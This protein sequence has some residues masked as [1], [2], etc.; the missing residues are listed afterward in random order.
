MSGIILRYL[1]GDG[2]YFTIVFFILMLVLA[3]GMITP[4]IVSYNENNWGTELNSKIHNIEITTANF[5]KDKETQLLLTHKK[6][7]QNLLVTLS[8]P[9]TSYRGLIKLVNEEKYN[10]YSVEVLAPNGR[11][12]AWNA[13]IA[14]KEENIFPLTFP[15][16]Q[17]FFHNTE[18]VTYLSVVDTISIE[19]DAFYLVLSFPFEKHYTIQN[20]YFKNTSFIN[21]LSN[22]FYTQFDIGFNS[23]SEKSKDGRKYS[24]DLLN[25]ADKKIGVV[26][27][28]KPS[29][30]S[31]INSISNL[32]DDFQAVLVILACLIVAVGFRKDFKN[33]K[34]RLFRFTLLIIY[35]SVLRLLLYSLAIPARF[36]EG[37]LTD[38]AY[39]SSAFGG[40]IVKS[41]VE[42]FITSL[43]FLI[44]AVY[45]FRSIFHYLKDEAIKKTG[46]RIL[47]VAII[48]SLTIIF[49]LSVRA[50]AATMKSIIFDSAIRYFKE[51]EIIPNLP[52]L[53][54]NL[55]IFIF[56]AGSV[57]L[58]CSFIMLIVFFYIQLSKKDRIRSFF[59][60]FVV[61]EIFGLAFFLIQNEPLVTPLIMFIVIAAIFLLSYHFYKKEE[62]P[63]NYIYATLVASLLTILL[64]NHFNL[65]LER[66]SLKTV[67]Y[68]I[69]RPND[70]LLHFHIEETL[71]DAVS[72]PT[73]V[74]YFLR[75]NTNYD[76]VAFLIWCNSSLQRESLHSSVSLYNRNM[77]LVGNF[78][79]GID[80]PVF[81][82]SKFVGLKPEESK[83]FIPEKTSDNYDQ[84]F[85]GIVPVS[86][87]EIIIGY[88]SATVAFDLQLMGNSGIP[89]FLES[90]ENILSPVVDVKQLKIFEFTDSRVSRI[91]GDIYPS[92][93][94]MRPIWNVKYSQD[95]DAWLTLTLN[96]E[97]Y[98]TYLV[99]TVKGDTQKIIAVLL[100][101]KQFT[102]NLFNFFKIFVIHSIF[103]LILFI[104]IF[105]SRI[106]KIKYTFKAQVLIAFLL[107]SIIPVV[108]LAI[109][110]RQVV[111]ERSQTAVVD[112]LSERANYLENHIY[113]QNE[114]HPEK[115]IKALFSAAGKELGISF[116]AYKVTDQTFNSSNEYYTS[117][118][119]PEKMNPQAYYHLNYLSYREYLTEEKIENFEYD[120]F[121]KKITVNNKDFIINVND[122]FN[123]VDVIFSTLDMDT[124]LFGIYSLAVLIIIIMSTIL[125]NNISAPIRRLTKATVAIAQGDMNVEIVHKEKSEIR[126]LVQSFNSMTKELQKNQIE[127]AEL[128]RENA[129]KEMAKQ[130]AHEIK[131]P[132]TPLKLS[133]QQLI[134]TFRDKSDKFDSVFEKVTQTILTQIENLSTIAT[135]F[136][137]FAKMPSLKLESMDLLPVL[138]DT[139][140]LF[141]EERANIKLSSEIDLAVIE[142]DINQFRRMIINLIRNSIQAEATEVAIQ[143]KLIDSNYVLLFSDNGKGIS[144]KDK[145]KIFEPSFTTK[146][147]GMGIG[148][149][150]IKRFLE[151]INGNIILLD[152]SEMGTTFKITIPKFVKL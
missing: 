21:D 20:S 101:E 99:K 137:R 115:D 132:L 139:L 51:P 106:K 84:V 30:A 107:I 125:A 67:A 49:F 45:L 64:L 127:L 81:S 52:A 96:D 69:T 74:N 37:E 136:S 10:E 150:L 47:Q 42:L 32:A 33:I 40:G 59:I 124:F 110:N 87:N 17:V 89:D 36:I 68:E 73:I 2:K 55:N 76:A 71:N 11:I 54:M 63:Y 65:Q 29:F 86:V 34:H 79:M 15:L 41:P 105:V 46:I 23:Y 9:N 70:N 111:K 95:N 131:N 5:F 145:N 129:W 103:I 122:A 66:D 90:K 119:F 134:A 149:K 121:Y 104:F 114:E 61:F 8:P 138:K 43:F 13:N 112:E 147:K 93:D 82:K 102:W 75:R 118:L 126:D 14:I 141:A 53:F 38:P 92:R 85:T 83:I 91:Y 57:L 148:L 19:H 24:F 22:K 62:S 109:Y 146:K 113:V 44:I 97:Q 133:V 77:E 12:I 27:F 7:K 39:F 80:H 151:G 3:I 98:L 143:V 140:N 35:M 25:N 144:E 78:S 128:E 72:N 26:S 31:Y 94:H 100:R 120:S 18:L 4:V 116:G 108:L 135:E 56:G 88:V 1:R 123:K 6:L 58:L 152:T 142:T 28:I 16:G 60:A 48:I 130:V 50:V 117:G